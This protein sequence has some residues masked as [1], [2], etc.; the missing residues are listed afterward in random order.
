[1]SI[2]KVER[3]IFGSANVHHVPHVKR[4][5]NEPVIKPQI[6][7]MIPIFVAAAALRSISRSFPA[8]YLMEYTTAVKNRTDIVIHI[9]TCK[10]RFLAVSS[11]IGILGI[12]IRNPTIITSVIQTAI[13]YFQSFKI[14][15]S[16]FWINSKY[17]QECTIFLV[18]SIHMHGF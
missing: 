1:M 15:E 7:N 3:L 14:V 11:R 5:H 17:T 16:I 2:A 8:R 12:S 9:G 18:L 13:I 10:N 6:P 4:D